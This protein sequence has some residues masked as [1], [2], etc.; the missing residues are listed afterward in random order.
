MEA[1]VLSKAE[2]HNEERTEPRIQTSCLNISTAW[3]LPYWKYLAEGKLPEDKRMADKIRRQSAK[4]V[5][6]GTN[7]YRWGYSSPLQKCVGE[8][9]A[10]EILMEVHEGLCASHI[11]SKVL[12]NVVLR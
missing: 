10:E 8:E 11:K 3:R 12:T 1:D 7:L 5:I 6:I 2:V 4:F 9:D